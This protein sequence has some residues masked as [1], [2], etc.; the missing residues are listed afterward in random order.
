METIH[1]E[2]RNGYSIKIYPDYDYSETPDDWGNDDVFLVAFHRDFTVER[3]GFDIETMR[4]VMNGGKYEDGSKHERAQEILH[5][6]HI[7]GLEAYIHSGVHLSLSHEGNYPDRQWD[8]SQLGCVMVEKKSARMKKTARERALG[9]L[10][11]WNAVLEGSVYGYV[12]ED[13][14]HG[15]TFNESCWGYIETEYPIEKT[16]VLQEARSVADYAYKQMLESH[17]AKRKEQIKAGAP[18]RVREALA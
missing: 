1:E 13:E 8:V 9:L 12:V 15:T 5:D 6:Y 14:T 10:E 2:T 7:F 17:I 11:T 4:A 3:D 18:L 16:Y